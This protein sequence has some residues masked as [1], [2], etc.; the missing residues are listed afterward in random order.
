MSKQ[1]SKLFLKI[2]QQVTEQIN[3]E[4]NE[5][6]MENL[7]EILSKI[8][9]D[10]KPFESEFFTG[11]G[12]KKFD[13]TMRSYGLSTDNIEFLDF[14]QSEICKKILTT[15]K[16]KIHVETDNIYY[17]NNNTRKSIFVFFPKQQD[18]TKGI[19]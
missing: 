6:D 17:N 19:I 4:K 12:N 2:D 13:D 1:I 3:D 18:P 16:V 5:L 8:G 7:T 14:L 11:G 15:N 10:E 9:D